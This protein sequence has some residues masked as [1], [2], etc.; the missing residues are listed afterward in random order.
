MKESRRDFETS[1]FRREQHLYWHR[2]LQYKSLKICKLEY[3]QIYVSV[4]HYL[5]IDCCCMCAQDYYI[6]LGVITILFE[7]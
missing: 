5:C 3:Q 1:D 2:Y 6:L 7:S 4:Q